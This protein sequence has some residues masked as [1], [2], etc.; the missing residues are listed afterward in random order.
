MNFVKVFEARLHK[1]ETFER[2]GASTPDK[3]RGP[4]EFQ[5]EENPLEMALYHFT[6]KSLSRST[7]NTVGAVA[8]RAGC[9]LEDMRTGE[10]F[11]YTH[12]AVEHI[13]LL[14]PKNAPAWS[15]EIQQ[16]MAQNREIGVQALCMI[17][18]ASET[19]I[20]ARVWREFELALHR[21]L[22]DEQNIALAREFVEEQLC[23]RGMA[24]QL[25]FHFDVDQTTGDYK[26]HCHVLA[27][28]RTLTEIGL[29]V[30]KE[31][32]WNK[33]ELLSELREQW[34]SYSNFHLKLHGHDVQIDHRSYYERGIEMEP[35]PKR[36]KNVIEQE[37][38][39]KAIE[40][41]TGPFTEKQQAFQNIQ[42]R[43]IYRILR[44]PEVVLDIVS[45]HH[46]TFMWADV[47]KVLHRYIDELPL[48]Q[49]MEARLRN[50][51]E[52]VTLKKDD[53]A[54][55]T[56]KSLL[57]AELN[58]VEL[59]E[60]LASKKSHQ[61][62]FVDEELKN[63]FSDEQLTALNHMVGPE[64][65]AC[66]FGIAGSGKTTLL[67]TCKNI[68]AANDY[69]VYGLAPTGKAAQNLAQSEI[70]SMTIHKFLKEFES[71]R[72]RYNAKS[73]LIVDEAG[74]VDLERFSKLLTA[75]QQLG[76]KLVV[77]GDGAQLQPVEAGPAFRL[78]T[79]RIGK[80]ELTTVVR[81]QETWQREATVLFGKQQTQEAVQRYMDK[82]HVHIIQ[83][84]I[85]SPE[86]G[87]YDQRHD[88]KQ[89]LLKAWHSEFKSN[90]QKSTLML[91]FTNRDVS[92]LN[93][94]AR[95]LLKASNYLEKQEFLYTIKKQTEDDFGEQK[96]ISEDKHFSKGDRIVF[97][98]NNYG[99]GVKNGTIGTILN[100]NQQKIQVR[101]EEGRDVSFAPKLYPFF[102]HGWAVTI[103][104]SQGTTIDKSYVL[105]SP[106]MTKNLTYVAMTRHRDD[107]QVYGS[108]L[109]FKK[110]EILPEMLSRSGEKLAATDY[111]DASTLME[112]MVEDE[113]LLNKLF[114]RLSDELHAMGAVSKKA[115]QHVVD[116]FMG[117]SRVT[118]LPILSHSIR[119]EKRAEKILPQKGY[120]GFWRDICANEFS[121][122]ELQK[123]Q[124]GY[125]G[126]WRDTSSKTPLPHELHQ[127]QQEER[128]LTNNKRP[129][130]W[131]DES[132]RQGS[133]Q[134]QSTGLQRDLAP[135]TF[136]FVGNN[137]LAEITDYIQSK[138][139]TIT[140]YAGTRLAHKAKDELHHYMTIL[141]KHTDIFQEL[142]EHNQQLVKEIEQRFKQEERGVEY[143]HET[144]RG[145]D[146]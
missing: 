58:L 68:W 76:T 114:G 42:F 41:N 126:F 15:V 37:K 145:L 71:G 80:R 139:H 112:R 110:P 14:L 130:L 39:L 2:F 99:L 135:P 51:S 18:E 107:V 33:K 32:N 89:A 136:D 105:A 60:T 140:T 22:T 96:T 44:R 23:G 46:A 4:D 57:K 144:G 20:N 115:F 92:D 116:Q 120:K 53:N 70:I 11:N 74:M 124:K 128:N 101:L 117:N 109:D 121:P 138:L 125:K 69:K 8:Y 104:K 21:E 29:S 43:N 93:K 129:S 26:P 52:L 36:G 133:I 97:I 131:R 113:K 12:K 146:F 132:K 31:R 143:I 82:G 106:N 78:L 142:K 127:F 86:Q 45:K 25:N 91:T 103:H 122:P 47:Q 64:Q 100:L 13:E 30:K 94:E 62:H 6:T 75:V 98:R 48:F 1:G 34:A 88:T 79:D 3:T 38:R 5:L 102:D 40:G 19:K 55:Y 24:S 10:V 61:S 17:A 67:K 77:M 134:S 73:V 123:T 7:R 87:I 63:R 50:S 81:Q 83:E 54:I 28:T 59:A 56:T 85:S 66:V 49:R 27:L 9:K 118:E 90:S 84:N 16:V 72:Y 95:F 35:Q 111:M 141:E 137:N 108:S 119:E 65:L